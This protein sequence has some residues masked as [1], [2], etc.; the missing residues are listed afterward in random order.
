MNSTH[1]I[2]Y[3]KVKSDNPCEIL[4][5][6]PGTDVVSIQKQRAINIISFYYPMPGKGFDVG[7]TE[8]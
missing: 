4:T 1:L 2:G 7:D 8:E 3:M 5:T 6:A